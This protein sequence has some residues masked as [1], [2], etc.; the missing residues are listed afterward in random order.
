MNATQINL[1]RLLFKLK[2]H[3][4]DGQAY[5]DLFVK[6]MQIIHP[7]LRPVKAYGREGDKKNDCFDKREGCYYQVY[8]PEE[9]EKRT[10]T[11]RKKLK[12]DF[13]GLY[14]FWNDKVA[15]VKKFFF[16]MN[17]K[18]KGCAPSIEAE[19][20]EIERNY[21]VECDPYLTKD[22]MEVF[23]SL[24]DERIFEIVGFLP[25][26]RFISDVQYDMMNDV[27]THLLNTEF[28]YEKES[29]PP[30]PDFEEKI[31]FNRLNGHTAALLR[32][33]NYQNYL[34]KDY[35]LS[36]PTLKTDLQKIFNGLYHQGAEL[37]GC[38]DSDDIF[39]YILSK[40]CPKMIKPVQDA[41]LVLMAYYF[42]YCDIFETPD[43]V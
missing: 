38:E 14:S 28:A 1:A 27:V 19:L 4:S 10:T 42:E 37:L 40:A 35:F 21:P 8:A 43:K 20:A 18:F 11:A 24:P 6:V 9:L 17:D 26:M 34:I 5:Q 2:I 7:D 15:P 31:R 23:L 22:L 39:M 36:N 13:E 3:E 32:Q 12:D 25:E 16:V 41:V 30:S 29:I 33:G